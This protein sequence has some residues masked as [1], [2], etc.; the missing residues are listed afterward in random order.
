VYVHQAN[1]EAKAKILGPWTAA[2]TGK[3]TGSDG[4]QFVS[5]LH[6]AADIALS[7]SGECFGLGSHC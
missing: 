1:P 6:P 7:C 3:A 2:G 5:I 4:T